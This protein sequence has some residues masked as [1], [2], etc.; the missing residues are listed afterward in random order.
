MYCYTILINP[1]LQILN[2]VSLHQNDNNFSYQC[3]WSRKTGRNKKGVFLQTDW[4]RKARGGAGIDYREEGGGDLGAGARAPCH[5]LPEVPLLPCTW[6]HTGGGC[7]LLWPKLDATAWYHAGARVLVSQYYPVNPLASAPFLHRWECL[8]VQ[9][10]LGCFS[11]GAWFFISSTPCLLNL[12]GIYTWKNWVITWIIGSASTAAIWGGTMFIWVYGAGLRY[13]APMIGLWSTGWGLFFQ[14]IQRRSSYSKLELWL[15]IIWSRKAPS[16]GSEFLEWSFGSP[17]HLL[18]LLTF[19]TFI[20]WNLILKI[21]KKKLRCL[22]PNK[23]NGSI[24]VIPVSENS[25]NAILKHKKL[26]RLLKI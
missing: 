12:E 13:P 21:K 22:K 8:A 10:G 26:V 18:E 2:L 3:F 24:S 11:L 1:L 20:E 15:Q 17:L 9:C 19:L 7:R 16:P 23:M 25:W 6:D 4:P 5:H 14:V